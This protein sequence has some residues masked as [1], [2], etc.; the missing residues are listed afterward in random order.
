MVAVTAA[1]VAFEAYALAAVPFALA[2]VF[3][4]LYHV[5]SLLLAAVALTPLSVTLKESDFN[6]GLSLPGEE[7]GRAHV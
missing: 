4:A 7:I 5:E 3:W 1:V 6:V 2:V